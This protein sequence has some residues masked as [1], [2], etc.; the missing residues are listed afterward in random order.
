MGRP[1]ALSPR[2]DLLITGVGVASSAYCLGRMSLSPYSLV[3]GIGFVGSYTTALP[4]GA[5]VIVEYDRFA[6][7]GVPLGGDLLPLSRTP[8]PPLA[9]A[10]E[11]GMGF[12]RV[13]T[14]PLD[15]FRYPRVWG[16]TVAHP[17]ERMDYGALA[18]GD[19]PLGVEGMEGAVLGLVAA[20]AACD[21]LSLRVVSNYCAPRAAAQWNV[22]LAKQRLAEAVAALTRAL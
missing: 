18:K 12:L 2:L 21:C 11:D 4:I 10:M 6:D 5:I 19:L 7:Y 14:I 3:V 16:N 17:S 20:E 22:A 9:G 1:V 13:S 8:F 15:C